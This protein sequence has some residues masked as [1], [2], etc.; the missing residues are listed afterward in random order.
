MEKVLPKILVIEDDLSSITLLKLI[1][2]AYSELFVAL[3]G[4]EALEMADKFSPDLVLVDLD[5]PDISGLEVCRRLKASEKLA[6]VPVVFLTGYSDIMFEAQAFEAG[7]IDYIVKPVSPYR[8]LMRVNA[9][10]RIRMPDREKMRELLNRQLENGED[11][12]T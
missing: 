3:N 6:E 10:L 5:L 2:E 11:Y 9:H 8:V 12:S 1:L 4:E 7:A